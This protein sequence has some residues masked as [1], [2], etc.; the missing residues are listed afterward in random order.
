MITKMADSAN[1][2]VLASLEIS[3]YIDNGHETV[4]VKNVIHRR[5]LENIHS[6]GMLSIVGTSDLI[7]WGIVSPA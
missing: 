7:T 1:A 3:R 5:R 4:T 6:I 2:L